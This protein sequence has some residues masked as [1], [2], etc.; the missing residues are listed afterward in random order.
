MSSVFEALSDRTRRRILEALRDAHGEVSVS[1][2]VDALG[3]SQPTVSKHLRVLREHGLVE[4][5]EE[6]QRRLYRVSAERLRPVRD[7]AASFLPELTPTSPVVL[8]QEA[9]AEQAESV[10]PA[11]RTPSDH[12]WGRL[13]TTEPHI[14][15]EVAR[16]VGRAAA[17]VALPFRRATRWLRARRHRG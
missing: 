6:G 5:R 16:V 3:V 17:V 9:L 7:W 8:A 11:E 10:R 13:G 2:L 1:A 4:V 12:V 15:G 14:S